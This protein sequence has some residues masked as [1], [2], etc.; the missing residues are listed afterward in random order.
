MELHLER[1]ER[2][3]CS[4]TL[5]EVDKAKLF[6]EVREKIHLRLGSLVKRTLS[7]EAPFGTQEVLSGISLRILDEL[8]TLTLREWV[9]RL[10]LWDYLS[11]CD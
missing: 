9:L 4:Q 3:K 7:D 6:T 11:F 8:Y 2:L 5:S 1:G 10:L